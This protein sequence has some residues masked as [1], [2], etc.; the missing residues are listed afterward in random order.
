MGATTRASLSSK[1]FSL[2][3]AARINSEVL[4]LHGG[5]R[6]GSATLDQLRHRPPPP[7]TRLTADPKDVLFFDMM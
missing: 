7:R 1:T 2:L 4:L 5:R 3:P 6:T